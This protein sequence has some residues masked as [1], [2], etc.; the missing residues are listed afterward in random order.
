MKDEK[1]PLSLH[2]KELRL[3]LLI[4]LISVFIFALIS[5]IYWHKII[6][7]IWLKDINL[8]FI[9]PQEAFLTRIKVSII[10]GI[11]FSMPFIMYQIWLFIKPA[12]TK[13][14]AKIILVLGTVSTVLFFLAIYFNVSVVTPKITTFF[15][16]SAQPVLTPLISV[17]NYISFL[18]NMTIAFALI[19]QFPLMMVLASTLGIVE[20]ESF[21]KYRKPMIIVIFTLAAIITPPDA[22]SQL[23]LALPMWGLYEF[24]LILVK[25]FSKF[26][27][28]KRAG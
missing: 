8:I 11:L 16:K 26:E 28:T 1:L 17:S 5:F 21:G 27:K 22:L 4:S 9:S 20:N 2:L 7:L 18:L 19:S 6:N 25:V 14:E 23:A 10:C 12:L 13:R 24:G 3:R 15:L